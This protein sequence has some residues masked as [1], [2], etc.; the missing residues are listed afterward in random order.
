M[1]PIC[2]CS[3]HVTD[4]VHGLLHLACTGGT[5]QGVSMSLRTITNNRL[6]FPAAQSFE[7]DCKLQCHDF[8]ATKCIGSAAALKGLGVVPCNCP[9]K[10]TAS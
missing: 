2:I 3:K 7:A 5:I 4:F 1:R 8:L 10:H 9:A 6:M